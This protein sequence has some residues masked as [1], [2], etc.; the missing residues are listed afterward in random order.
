ME[1]SISLGIVLASLIVS[2]SLF[3]Q[4]C[5]KKSNCNSSLSKKAPISKPKEPPASVM[6]KTEMTQE[7]T[8]KTQENS[9]KQ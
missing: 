4:C 5:K 3:V 6:I 1:W 8:E 2:L 7:E 9:I